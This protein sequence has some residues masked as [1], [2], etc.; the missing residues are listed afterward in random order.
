MQIERKVLGPIG[1][2]VYLV[3]NTETKKCVVIDPSDDAEKIAAWI[4]ARGLT[5]EAI[6]LTH[7]H[8]D[9]C[10]DAEPLREILGVKMYALDKEQEFLLDPFYNGDARFY[11]RNLQVHPD[12]FLHDRQ[13]IE[14]AGEKWTVLWTPGH[15]PGSCCFYIPDQK[16]LF[17]GDTL[18]RESFGRFDMPGG[19][20]TD[21]A[22]S[23][24][25]LL[26]TL[27]ESVVVYPGHMDETT[28]GYEKRF[29]PLA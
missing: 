13:V 9:H 7:G 6:L 14:F 11:R 20:V 19:S 2:N 8:F 24:H 5:P 22:N 29:N 26:E 21:I 18:F 27:P 3:W 1:T 23:V 15:T 12:E 17:S 28:I 4:K 25:S 10:M 16:A